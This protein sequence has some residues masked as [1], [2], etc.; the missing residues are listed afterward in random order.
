MIARGHWFCTV[1]DDV[2]YMT[3]ER[4]TAKD[5]PCPSCG[6]CSCNFVPLKLSRA[7]IAAGWFD[8]MR[9]KVDEATNPELPD[10]GHHKTRR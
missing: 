5:V 4:T 3:Y 7:Q 6:H 2:V 1:C 10:M 9:R 8:A